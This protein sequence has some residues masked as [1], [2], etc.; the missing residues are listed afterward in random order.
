MLSPSGG[1]TFRKSPAGAFTPLGLWE[2]LSVFALVIVLYAGCS[3]GDAPKDEAPPN[4]VLIIADD[5]NWDDNGAYG[6][7]SNRTPNIDRLAR[8]GGESSRRLPYGQGSCARPNPS[9]FWLVHVRARK[10]Q[11]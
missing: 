3:P 7:P 9:W 4:V 11:V 1:G 8:E 10:D 5:M 6:H 2:T